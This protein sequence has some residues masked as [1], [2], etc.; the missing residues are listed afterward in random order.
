MTTCTLS[1][2]HWELPGLAMKINAI[3]ADAVNSARTATMLAIEAGELLAQAKNHVGHG[4]WETWLLD[5][6]H[7]AVRTAQA[8]MRLSSAFPFL[9]EEKRNAVAD[10][11]VR[12]AVKAITTTAADATLRQRDVVVRR[13][14]RER[15]AQLLR[16]GASNMREA[17]RWIDH[18]GEYKARRVASLRKKLIDTVAMLDGLAADGGAA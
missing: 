15:V 1:A 3:T 11:P 13:S 7:L 5:N 8:Y 2:E 17:A 10:M 9:T 12:M 16:E 6:C 4:N 14:E 18:L